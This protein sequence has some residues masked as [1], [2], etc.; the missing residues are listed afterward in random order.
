[1]LGKRGAAS[2]EN[3]LK[4]GYIVILLRRKGS[5]APFSRHFQQLSQHVDL[6]FIQH[7][8]VDKETKK[9]TFKPNSQ[10][11]ES[12][13]Q[14]ISV[15]DK[16]VQD[17]SLLQIEFT[18]IVE[19]LFYLK[20]CSQALIS[21]GRRG[22]IYACAAVSDFYVPER[23]MVQHK[24]QSATGP[25]EL[26]LPQ[27]PKLLLLL[28]SEWVPEAFC[29][30]FKLETD[31][32]ILLEK[33]RKAIKGYGMDVVV[34]NLLHSRNYKVTLVAQGMLTEIET[35]QDS[36]SQSEIE[37]PLCQTLSDLHNHFITQ[38]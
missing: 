22:M 17:G 34:A 4:L 25:L 8:I 10:S 32:K 19:Y 7:L 37:V 13:M 12:L 2:V 11:N 28:R 26:T 21:F 3:F 18:T 31:S 35:D 30:S 27:T 23:Q 14:A 15:Y 24:I 36:N 9:I 16:I 29:V 33:A 20:A 6:N 5:M 38:G 1:L